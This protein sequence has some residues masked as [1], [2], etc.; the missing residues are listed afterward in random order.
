MESRPQK[1]AARTATAALAVVF[2][3][4]L[5]R[6]TLSIT[7]PAFSLP[8]PSTLRH[9]STT[10]AK[11]STVP[12]N[13]A[14]KL[15]MRPPLRSLSVSAPSSSVKAA[16]DPRRSHPS[17]SPAVIIADVEA[18]L[19]STCLETFATPSLPASRCALHATLRPGRP[20][21]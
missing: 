21:G 6:R 5:T 3:S 2:A 8:P 1:V 18:M 17:F 4:A 19:S 12:A 13:T 7:P 16:P 9:M 10:T 11:T 14:V 20:G 15:A